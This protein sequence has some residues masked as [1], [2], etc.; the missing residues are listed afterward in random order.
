MEEW[1]DNGQLSPGAYY[2]ILMIV[3]Y[4]LKDRDYQEW[5]YLNEFKEEGGVC[6]GGCPTMT[7][8]S[9]EAS[10]NTG[11]TGPGGGAA[12]ERGIT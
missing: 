6:V 7:K 4:K 11:S 2:Q 3:F 5:I 8:P 12:S 1:G 9:Q 10:V